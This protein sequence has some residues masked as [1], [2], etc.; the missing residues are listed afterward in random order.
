MSRRSG[1]ILR[2]AVTL[3]LGLAVAAS[4]QA[5][6]RRAQYRTLKLADGR[7]IVAEVVATEATGLRLRTPQGEMLLSFE[8][9]QDMSPADADTYKLQEAWFV[10]VA[11]PP[12]EQDRLLEAFRW[13]P[14]TRVARTGEELPGLA[15]GQA[16]A[17]ERC[18]LDF[19]CL[20]K[21]TSGAPWMYVVSVSV[22]EAGAVVANSGLNSGTTKARV[23][24]P[25]LQADQL[26]GLVHESLLLEVPPGGPPESAFADP[27]PSDGPSGPSGPD[28]APADARLTALAFAPVP[29]LPAMKQKNGAGLGAAIAIAVAGTAAT[30]GAA[31]HTSQSA[32]ELV[33]F[34]LVGFYASTVFANHVTIKR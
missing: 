13:V 5:Q 22:D 17:A 11:A 34:S 9:L 6:D 27:G 15:A 26:W 12:A 25:G 16:A 7:E 24:K 21:E 33:G 28:A 1:G 29:G 30:V 14:N 31:G 3:A 32:P 19:P 20:L 4:A 23:E 2:G 18:K 8:L 10:Y